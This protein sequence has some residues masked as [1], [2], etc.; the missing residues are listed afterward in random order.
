[1][2]QYETTEIV[3]NIPT[4]YLKNAKKIVV[5]ITSNNKHTHNFL[6]IYNNDDLIVNKTAGTVTV[7]IKQSDTAYFEAE[8]LADLQVNILNES[9]ARVVSDIAKIKISNTEYKEMMV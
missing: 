9:G 7:K 4:A 1:M 6:K 8:T 2:R 3:L 5:T